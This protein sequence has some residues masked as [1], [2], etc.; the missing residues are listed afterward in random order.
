MPPVSAERL[1][2]QEVGYCHVDCSQG[3]HKGAV[4]RGKH[5]KGQALPGFPAFDRSPCPTTDKAVRPQQMQT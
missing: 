5:L 2:M 4:V 1:V 3:A